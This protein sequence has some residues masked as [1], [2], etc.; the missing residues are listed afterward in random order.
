MSLEILSPSPSVIL[1]EANKL[2]NLS[3][4]SE[5][6]YSESPSSYQEQE[7]CNPKLLSDPELKKVPI[8]LRHNRSKNPPPRGT[9]TQKQSKLNKVN[10]DLRSI[11]KNSNQ[12]QLMHSQSFQ[13]QQKEEYPILLKRKSIVMSPK[14]D[15]QDLGG[16]QFL[17]I[18]SVSQ[19][20][21]DFKKVFPGAV[22]EQV[23]EIKNKTSNNLALRI[24]AIC[25][26]EILSQMEEY[27]FSV[28]EVNKF[29]YHEKLLIVLQAKSSVR[30]S[31]GLKVPNLKHEQSIEGSYSIEIIGLN[32]IITYNLTAFIQIPKLISLKEIYDARSNIFVIKFALKKGKKHDFKVFFR[33]ENEL[34]LEGNFEFLENQRNRDSEIMLYPTTASIDGFS[35]FALNFMV[36]PRNPAFGFR[37]Q[38]NPTTL[39][40]VL[41]FKVKNSSLIYFF[42]LAIEL[43]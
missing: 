13:L 10:N 12:K 31:L 33:N 27:V 29:N 30:F 14:A 5:S 40:K 35:T 34:K 8:H 43:Y 39:N 41:L 21:I 17:E 32:K 16:K 11:L 4:D 6:L 24:N 23:I 22:I 38:T 26:D 15:Y 20:D 28:A 37:N 2:E 18:I 3:T 36:K 1:T 25:N 9:P 42:A 7:N 19:C